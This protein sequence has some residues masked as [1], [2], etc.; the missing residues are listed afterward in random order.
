[1]ITDL[2]SGSGN[3]MQTVSE[4]LYG[5]SVGDL[6]KMTPAAGSGDWNSP[7]YL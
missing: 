6:L 3:F 4:F 1:M 5:N 2:P 7:M